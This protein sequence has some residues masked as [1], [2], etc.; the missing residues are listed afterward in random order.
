MTVFPGLLLAFVLL[1]GPTEPR[2]F[3]FFEPVKPPR[4]LQ[5]MAHRGAARQAPENTAPALE[6]SIADG[7]E[8]V[9]VD[10]R[11][12]R[13][14][15]HVLFHDEMVDAKTNGRG[16]VRDRTLAELPRSTP[17]TGLP[18]DSPAPGYSP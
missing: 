1:S 9:E 13:D 5:V 10:V 14:G 6:R 12:T 4:G 2:A 18:L 11:L 15:H 8:W 3:S 7:F 16:R 17:A